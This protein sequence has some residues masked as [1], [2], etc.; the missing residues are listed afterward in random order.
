MPKLQRERQTNSWRYE[1][2]QYAPEVRLSRE[3]VSW[4]HS[5]L[6]LVSKSVV[7]SLVIQLLIS[8][9]RASTSA[10]RAA[11]DMESGGTTAPPA[12]EEEDEDEEDVPP[13]PNRR[14]ASSA[15]ALARAAS[16]CPGPA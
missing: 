12:E 16:A 2:L 11:G 6:H 8:F 10:S 3:F 9:T 1:H 4:P 13:P 14:A 15:S 5:S 7:R